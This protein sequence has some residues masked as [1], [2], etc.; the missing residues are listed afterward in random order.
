MRTARPRPRADT[1]GHTLHPLIGRRV[2]DVASGRTGTLRAVV[3]TPTRTPIGT[4][5]VRLAYLLPDGGGVEW[6][7]DPD[8]LREIT[9]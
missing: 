9:A 2:E 3:N 8:N 6:T 1:L 7:T 4:R 5:T